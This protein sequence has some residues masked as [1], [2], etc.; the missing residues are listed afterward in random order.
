MITTRS[1]ES[2]R[3]SL[4]RLKSE[5]VDCACSVSP[6]GDA[7][8]NHS[9][10][11][12]TRITEKRKDIMTAERKM[13]FPFTN[14]DEILYWA[15]RYTKRQSDKRRSQEEDVR[16]IK[17]SVED[18]GYLTKC[19][20]MEMARWKD[21]RFA[22]S[23]IKNGNSSGHIEAVTREAFRPGDDWEKLKKLMGYYD[24]ICG[25][26]QSIAST[27]L[28]LYDPERYPIFDPHALYSIRIKKKKSKAIKSFGRNMSNSAVRNPIVMAFVCG[29]WIERY[30]NFHRAARHSHS[31]P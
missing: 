17:G 11:Y 6:R 31:K 29:P 5:I 3:V 7:S 9:E 16:K 20:L 28:H 13:L 2:S 12:Q 22:C 10:D 26:G 27:I 8:Q 25:V 23:N 24:G 4:A 1:A 15:D 14:H 19:E 21:P 18:K 30:I